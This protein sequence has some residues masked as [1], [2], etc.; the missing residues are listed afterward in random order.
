MMVGQKR[1]F[2]PTISMQ[3]NQIK[4]NKKNKNKT[5]TQIKIKLIGLRVDKPQP[6]N[7]REQNRLK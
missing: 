6:R 1:T 2:L 5:L 3:I 4:W 7:I